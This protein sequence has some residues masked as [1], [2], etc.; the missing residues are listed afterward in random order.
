MITSTLLNISMNL[1]YLRDSSVDMYTI[2]WRSLKNER[3]MHSAK[4]KYISHKT[5]G[6]YLIIIKRFLMTV[7][8]WTGGINLAMKKFPHKH[9]Q[10]HFY[11]TLVSRTVHPTNFK[12]WDLINNITLVLKE[13]S[14][15]YYLSTIFPI[16]SNCH[17]RM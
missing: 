11:K 15:L 4:L 9:P 8:K 13:F 7:Y 1:T 10:V 14:L 5:R 16:S 17:H 12:V 6:V 2:T 3:L